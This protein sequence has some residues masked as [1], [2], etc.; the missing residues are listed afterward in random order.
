MNKVMTAAETEHGW[1]DGNKVGKD[2][3]PKPH[4]LKGRTKASCRSPPQ[5]CLRGG[6]NEHPNEMDVRSMRK[7][8]MS[9]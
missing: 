2:W 7:G 4:L 8:L 9:K 3:Q 5:G 1:R 6:E